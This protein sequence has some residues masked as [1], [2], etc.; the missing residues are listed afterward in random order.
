MI[1]LT[2]SRKRKPYE[3]RAREQ[4][5]K[6][7]YAKAIADFRQAQGIEGEVTTTAKGLAWLLATCP[8]VTFRNGQ[9]A[10]AE[11]TK[12]CEA[13]RWNSSNCIDT[14]AAAYAEEK[15]FERAIDFEQLA[16]QKPDC[17]AEYRIEMEKRLAIY[18][19]HLPYRD[20][21]RR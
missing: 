3:Y 6:G 12:D 4:A 2:K 15:D 13:T 18:K 20:V 11:A 9:E 1:E 7:D 21:V 16:L 5:R 17:T 14:L 19:R 8:E 10:V